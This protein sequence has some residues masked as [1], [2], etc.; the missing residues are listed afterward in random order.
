MATV[1]V[2]FFEDLKDEQ[3]ALAGGKGRTL[4]RLFQAGYRVPPGLV[5]LASAFAGDVLVPE[6]WERI[7]AGL[8]RLR[9]ERPG[10]AF[11]VRSSALAEDS[12]QASFA[13][14]FETVLNVRDDDAVRAAI[15]TVR[16]SRHA[17]RVAQYSQA[18]GLASE[19][20]VAVVI[21]RMVAPDFSGVLF[22]ADPVTGNRAT[23]VGNAV[24][25][26]GEKL[27]S[28]EANASTFSL[29]R[30]GG[31]YTGEPRLR[32]FA[33]RFRQLAEQLERELGGPQDIEWALEKGRLWLLQA[34]PIT[35]LSG[36]NPRTGEHNDS[37]TGEYLW[38]NTNLGEAVPG[39]MTPC[40]WSLMRLFLAETL[41]LLFAHDYPAIGNIGGRFYLNLSLTVSIGAA[42]GMKQARLEKMSQETF[43]LLP[44]GLKAPR[45]PLST[46]RTLR[47]MI[48]G[49]V[50]L[51][52]RVAA[53][54]KRL[55]AFLEAA[56][57]HAEALHARIRETSSTAAL[58]TLWDTEVRPALCESC[59]ML[60]AGAR[61]N[62]T[63]SNTLRG[64][65][66]EWVG[67]A[68][69]NAL[70]AGVSGTRTL[71]SLETLVGLSQLARGEIDRETYL[72]RYGHRGPDEFEVSLPRPAEDPAW[73]DRQLARAREAPVDVD[74]L[75]SRRKQEQAAAWERFQQRH[76]RRVA[77]LRRQLQALTEW[78]HAREAT[79]SE[80]VRRFWVARTF[81]QRAGVLTGQG[82]AVF[83][84]EMDELLGLLRGDTTPLA[85][86][87]A[88][89]ETHARY[90][91]LPRYPSLIRGRFDPFQ[92]AADP[93][94]RADLFD[95]RGGDVPAAEAVTG[96]PGAAGVVE[97]RVRVLGSPEQG[98]QLQV[99]EILV[100][101][102]T[103][104]G[105][106]PLFPRAAAIV[107]DVGAPLSHAA[108]V[109]R[110]LGIPAVVGCGNATMRLRTGDQVRVNGAQGSV[111]VLHP[112]LSPKEAS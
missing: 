34:R 78:S 7:A 44:K 79:R 36:Y 11:A 82:D 67:N 40:T 72:R 90:A 66:S 46:W 64:Q 61:N 105:W 91:A 49:A 39:V 74:T 57:A 48:P 51:K 100:T 99:G 73:I 29:D 37:L 95:A 110:E 17:E 101:S 38:T 63:L 89:R 104:V 19:H 81:V 10:C 43:G 3:A 60:E 103:N 45:L 14:E 16:R 98:E 26:L 20:S 22:T 96:F 54:Q 50:R 6:A 23:I 65:L 1:P 15:D 52:R 92:W 9:A 62:G 27:V 69:A 87:P 31:D 41:P 93:R 18:Q 28:G 35:T 56:P 47:T 59:H 88:R 58:I 53:N 71:A 107:T 25:G 84:L 13:G 8:A 68:D 85:F 24:R 70:L 80:I 2:Y 106:T 30:L 94:R 42:F 83:F 4:A 112:V 76:P 108:I 77:S 111:E 109:A 86:I 102:V 12:A 21:Q 32:R 5:V 97:G 55:S 33:R 75:L